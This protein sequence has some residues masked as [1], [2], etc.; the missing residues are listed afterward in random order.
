MAVLSVG[1]VVGAAASDPSPSV[2]APLRSIFVLRRFRR[3]GEGK[4]L[5]TSTQWGMDLAMRNRVDGFEMAIGRHFSAP[6]FCEERN[7]ISLIF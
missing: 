1:S 2:V 7:I 4:D 3:I 5:R 6:G